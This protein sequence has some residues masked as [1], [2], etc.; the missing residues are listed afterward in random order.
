ML[1]IEVCGEEREGEREREREREKWKSVLLKFL[2]LNCG[3][4][5]AYIRIMTI[6]CSLASFKNIQNRHLA[7]IF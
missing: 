1:R 4:M 7:K 5:L 3:K 6:Y 2:N